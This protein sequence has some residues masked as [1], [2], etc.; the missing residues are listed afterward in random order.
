MVPKYRQEPAPTD[1]PPLPHDYNP[2]ALREAKADI[3]RRLDAHDVNLE[4]EEA[5]SNLYRAATV[6]S[7]TAEK[8]VM[9]DEDLSWTG[10]SVLWVLW[11]W[12]EMGSSRL[13]GELGL[14]LGT[15]TGVR[16][17]LEGQGLVTSRTDDGDARRRLISLT[18]SGELVIERIYPKF[19]QWATDLLGDLTPDEIRLLAR[20]LQTIILAPA[21]RGG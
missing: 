13:A 15:L 21:A 18:E 8:E 4:V 20:L 5:T 17:G 11:V 7:R 16:K 10:F 12:G 2:D 14:T 19:N 9:S 3:E 1:E 6:L